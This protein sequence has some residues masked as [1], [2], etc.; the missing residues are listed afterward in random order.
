M[1]AAQK[2]LII[3][4][5][6]LGLGFVLLIAAAWVTVMSPSRD[7]GTAAVGG[8][9]ALIGHEGQVVSHRDFAG[10]PFLVFFGFTNCPDVCPTKLFEIS[11]ILRAIGP[12]ARIS[13]LFITV[14]PER[15]TPERLKDYLSH[16]DDRIVGLTGSPAAIEQVLKAYR[17]YS[18]KV[19]TENDYTMDHTAL[20]Y[21][22]NRRG[23][24]VSGFN[25]A[26][27]PQEAAAE[28]K[29]HL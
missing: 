24:F 2:R 18:R 19:P 23:E 25:V 29:R 14:D 7:S 5:V 11:E 17:A 20:V 15:D 12:E 27:S 10:R 1:T 13:A 4:I 8:P 6:S 9:F 26:R 28:L 22:M 16:F 3:P 21:L